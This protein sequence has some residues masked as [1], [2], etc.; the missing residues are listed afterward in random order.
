M[1]R[2]PILIRVDF[3]VPVQDKIIQDPTRILSAR[4]TVDYFAQNNKVILISHFKDPKENDYA[5]SEYSFL[6]ILSEIEKYLGHKLL[7]AN[8]LDENIQN[9]IDTAPIS[10]VIL[11][12]NC[13]FWSGEKNCDDILSRRIA[14]F[15]R[16]FINEAFSCSHRNHASVVG[17]AKYLPTFPGYHFQEE[18]SALH[19]A[20]NTPSRPVL[21]IIGGAKISSK[22]PILENLLP[23]VDF[24]AIG[25]AMAHTFFVAKNLSVGCSLF[26]SEY[27]EK[28]KQLLDRYNDKIL[29]PSDTLVAMS[30]NDSPIVTSS[31]TIPQN[32][33]AYDIGPAT[34]SAWG[35][36][37]RKCNTVIWNGTLGVA[38]NTL[39]EVGS[40]RIAE[41]ICND[42]NVFSVVGGGDTLAAIAKFEL[43]DNFSHV[44][45]GGGAFLTWLANGCLV[46][47][48][49][50]TSTNFD[51]FGA[52]E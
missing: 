7:F 34:I 26:E 50:F 48:M 49:T 44:C 41:I 5:D 37:I 36:V 25:G 16:V 35:N 12:E 27:V 10:T 2:K 19:M 17:V 46:A 47:E 42:N 4:R 3:N 38:E 39:F 24:L 1:L 15:G 33:S 31:S 40:K 51:Q 52:Y 32:F 11:L 13:R 43:A 45:T 23:K 30:I 8:L 22:L 29:L 18:L 28:A 20:L 6:P 14:S 21:A 9:K